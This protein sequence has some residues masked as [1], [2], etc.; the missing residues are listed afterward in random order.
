[1]FRRS[2]LP[3]CGRAED[4]RATSGMHSSWPRSCESARWRGGVYKGS[5]TFASLRASS[6]AY[7]SLVTDSARIQ[8]RVKSLYRS[9]GVAASGQKVYA[10]ATREELLQELPGRLRPRASTLYQELEA[11]NEVKKGAAKAMLEEARKHKVYRVLKTPPG[12]G[13]IRTAQLLPIVVTPFR[14]A[15]K[16]SFWAYCGLAIVMR[17]SADWVRARDGSWVRRGVVD[18]VLRC[19]LIVACVP[20]VVIGTL[21]VP[22]SAP[23]A[24]PDRPTGGGDANRPRG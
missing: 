12:L 17:G 10:R 3:G 16:R 20:V 7:T 6:Q 24:R 4:R 2:W 19:P 21:P 22:R 8:N 11:V 5:R 18:A 23:A 15:N 9:R 13:P 14:F 1:M